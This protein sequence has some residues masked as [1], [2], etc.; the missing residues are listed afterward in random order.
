M[1]SR[2]RIFLDS[3]A[4]IAGIASSKGGA[5]EILVLAEA[6]IFKI[7]LSSQV[8]R[9]CEGNIAKK[10][11]QSRGLFLK[12]I[13]SLNPEIAPTP[14][15]QLIKRFLKNVPLGD[16]LILAAAE[17][18]KVDYFLHFDRKHF[19][20]PKIQKQVPF[21]IL[22]PGEFLQLFFGR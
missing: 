8:L 19:G 14:S 21:K 4:L 16:A 12:F 13:K 11:P 20:N 9:E 6:G 10:L 18:A 3:S 22:M 5:R 2:P 7:V 1:I 15:R 17:I